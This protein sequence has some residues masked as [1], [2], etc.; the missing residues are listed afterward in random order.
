M[1]QFSERSCHVLG[2]LAAY[3]SGVCLRPTGSDVGVGI[4]AQAGIDGGLACIGRDGY[5][6]VVA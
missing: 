4:R 1:A 5:C 2:I 3:G 6:E